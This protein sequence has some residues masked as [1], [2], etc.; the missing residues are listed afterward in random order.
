[1]IINGKAVG[2]GID[3]VVSASENRTLR[4]GFSLFPHL[5]LFLDTKLILYQDNIQYLWSIQ[6]DLI[7]FG[8]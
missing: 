6:P 8:G 5:F 2:S 1:M 4:I 7:L 3:M